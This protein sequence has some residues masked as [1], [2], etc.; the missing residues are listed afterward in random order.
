MATR[1]G[2]TQRKLSWFRRT[3]LNDPRD[4][5]SDIENI[6]KRI[7]CIVKANSDPEK[8]NPIILL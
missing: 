1:N 3:D 4:D 5:M 7:P 2:K 6:H 8:L